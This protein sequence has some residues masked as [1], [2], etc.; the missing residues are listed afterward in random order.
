MSP[1]DQID[2]GGKGEA[3]S[4][5]ELIYDNRTILAKAD[6]ALADLTTEGGVLQPA[7]A[8]KFIRILI[9]SP[10]TNSPL[11]RLT[12]VRCHDLMCHAF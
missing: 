6:L 12:Y 10:P 7:Q 11:S 8:K 5:D 4:M 2:E 1:F 9:K 3:M